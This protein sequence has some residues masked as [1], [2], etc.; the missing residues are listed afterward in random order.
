MSLLLESDD[1][2]PTDNRTL[3]QLETELELL[4]DEFGELSS[5][6]YEHLVRWLATRRRWAELKG[7]L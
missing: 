5:Q 7:V 6:Q 1:N 2:P 4:A 3:E